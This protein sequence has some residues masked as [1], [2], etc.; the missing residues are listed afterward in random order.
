MFISETI[1]INFQVSPSEKETIILRASENG[2]DDIST[3]LKVVALK[4][5]TFKLS[6]VDISKEES[7]VELTFN[8]SQAQKEQ[9]E[10]KMKESDCKD[11]STYLTY[12]ALHGVVTAVVEVRSTGNLDAMLQRIAKSRNLSL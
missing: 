8:V 6:P 1:H 3:Y 11:L 10:E 5:Q 2:F 9:I 7:S 4:I 12:I